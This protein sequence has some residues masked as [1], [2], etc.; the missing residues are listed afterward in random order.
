MRLDEFCYKY[1]DNLY[2]PS[3]MEHSQSTGFLLLK[4]MVVENIEPASLKEMKR[5]ENKPTLEEIS[6]EPD[7][8]YLR[9]LHPILRPHIIEN[10]EIIKNMEV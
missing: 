8:K 4:K 7:I 3:I 10:W 1:C 2:N 6:S 9:F 5:W